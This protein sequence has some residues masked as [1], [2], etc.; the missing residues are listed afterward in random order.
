MQC[1]K[2]FEVRSYGLCL[3]CDCEVVS[4]GVILS[5]WCVSTTCTEGPGWPTESTEGVLVWVKE[6]MEDYSNVVVLDSP[7]SIE[8][9]HNRV[10]ML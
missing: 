1:E 8:R 2:D 7:K 3:H 5:P 9:L 10:S 6:F 4:R